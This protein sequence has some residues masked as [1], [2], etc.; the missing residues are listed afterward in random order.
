MQSHLWCQSL[1]PEL[2]GLPPEPLVLCRAP[3][4]QRQIAFASAQISIRQKVFTGNWTTSL[5]SWFE[6]AESWSRIPLI[7]VRFPKSNLIPVLTFWAGILRIKLGI[8]SNVLC[9]RAS[10]WSGNQE[11]WTF[12]AQEC[13]WILWLRSLTVVINK[14]ESEP[15]SSDLNPGLITSGFQLIPVPRV[16]PYV[17]DPAD[18]VKN[19]S[20]FKRKYQL[21]SQVWASSTIRTHDF[22]VL[23]LEG[24]DD[25]RAGWRSDQWVVKVSR[26]SKCKNSVCSSTY[27]DGRLYF[28][29]RFSI[30][31]P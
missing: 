5:K 17:R 28:K 30:L 9:S 22:C 20:Y 25:P 3:R 19:C 8:E 29:A 4:V 13:Y 7:L 23:K 6:S 24:I 31:Q 2:S 1:H 21:Y 15:F 12:N 11:H 14:T 26:A 16:Q 27:W 18:W 10:M